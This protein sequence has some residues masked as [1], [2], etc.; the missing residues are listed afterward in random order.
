MPI[1]WKPHVV[2]LHLFIKD[3]DKGEGFV[4]YDLIMTVDR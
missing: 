3:S 4:D 2:A 1:L